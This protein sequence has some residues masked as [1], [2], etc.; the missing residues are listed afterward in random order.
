MLFKHD[1]ITEDLYCMTSDQYIQLRPDLGLVRPQA[2]V[3]VGPQPPH[4]PTISMR[5]AL[6]RSHFLYKFG[7]PLSPGG[8]QA[9][10]LLLLYM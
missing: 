4:T 1:Q 10:F 7:G 2:I 9:L 5:S 6:L 3:I 8:P